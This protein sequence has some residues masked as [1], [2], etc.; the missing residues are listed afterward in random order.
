[1]Y[2]NKLERHNASASR[3]AEDDF[4]WAEYGGVGDEIEVSTIND[5]Y[6]IVARGRTGLLPDDR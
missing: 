3:L 2:H 1:M 5:G 6:S 4:G